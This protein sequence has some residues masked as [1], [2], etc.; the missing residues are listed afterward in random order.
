MC[1]GNR[2]DSH[3]ILSQFLNVHEQVSQS[4]NIPRSA[5]VS[6]ISRPKVRPGG[7]GRP[8]AVVAFKL[9]KKSGVVRNLPWPDDTLGAEGVPWA[10]RDSV[11]IQSISIHHPIITPRGTGESD[12]FYR[13]PLGNCGAKINQ[14]ISSVYF[15]ISKAR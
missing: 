8:S 6:P 13:V 2:E 1:T 9:I 14:C 15:S 10:C 3:S 11:G 5:T 7:A 12:N 4:L